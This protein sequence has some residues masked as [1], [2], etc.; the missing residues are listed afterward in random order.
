MTTARQ[1]INTKH[2]SSSAAMCNVRQTAQ[3]P[4]RHAQPANPAAG[5]E[6]NGTSTQWCVLCRHVHWL[7][8]VHRAPTWPIASEC[9]PIRTRSRE[10]VT[11]QSSLVRLSAKPATVPNYSSRSLP[12]NMSVWSLVQTRL[13]V[14]ASL[15]Q[16]HCHSLLKKLIKRVFAMSCSW[17][18]MSY[19]WSWSC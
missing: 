9:R 18:L 19:S 10:L 12:S 3:L 1:H 11:L 5:C 16:W 17:E 15:I 2:S 4:R 6:P 7:H 8:T 14:S 13:F